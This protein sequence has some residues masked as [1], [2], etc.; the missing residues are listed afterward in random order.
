ML[1]LPTGIQRRGKDTP[2]Q[3]AGQRAGL[4]I[5]LEPGSFKFPV[6]RPGE[7]KNLLHGERSPAIVIF[8]KDTFSAHE[9]HAAESHIP[10]PG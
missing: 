7:N 10:L 9:T 3:T 6:K 8:T 2:A 1:K 4:A 5:L